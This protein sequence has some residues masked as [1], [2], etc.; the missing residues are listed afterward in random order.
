[1]LRAH[2][3]L[4][5]SIDNVISKLQF[6]HLAHFYTNPVVGLLHSARSQTLQNQNCA[7]LIDRDLDFVA[8]QLGL[9]SSWQARL[10]KIQHDVSLGKAPSKET[11]QNVTTDPQA[12]LSA[13]VTSYAERSLQIQALT[14]AFALLQTLA[15]HWPEKERTTEWLLYHLDHPQ[16]MAYSLELCRLFRSD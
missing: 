3:Q 11:L 15:G 13:L 10:Q 5:N 16:F 12:M 9:T 8:R 14:S 1:M 6:I 7:G 2:E 4:N